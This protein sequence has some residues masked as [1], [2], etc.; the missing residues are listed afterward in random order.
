MKLKRL[1]GRIQILTEAL[2][3]KAEMY[4]TPHDA[5]NH[6]PSGASVR[7]SRQR[8]LQKGASAAETCRKTGCIRRRNLQKDGL[9]PSPHHEKKPQNLHKKASNT[10]AGGTRPTP[11]C[12]DVR[13]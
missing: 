2:R 10:T 1:K 6:I 4:E 13:I 9:Y 7:F 3:T 12:R 11:R 5:L 8:N